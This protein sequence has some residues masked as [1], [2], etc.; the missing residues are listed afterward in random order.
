MNVP[1]HAIAKVKDEA[2]R[3]GY[4]RAIERSL[5]DTANRYVSL[6]RLEIIH[7]T[8]DHLPPRRSEDHAHISSHLATEQELLD[9][10]AEGTWD[11]TAELLALFR[12]G[13]RCLL[14]FVRGRRAGYTWVHTAGRPR[15]LPG[16]RI[17]IPD[18]YAYNFAGFT[19]PEFRGCGLQGYRHHELLGRPEWGDKKGLIGFVQCINWSSRRGQAKSGYRPLGAISLIGTRNRFTALFS[20]ELTQLGIR[21][22]DD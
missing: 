7:L 9:M 13:D 12:A 16:L 18:D 8:R 20:R 17:S 6:R 14:S 21:R 3:V 19:L 15:L 11:I 4:G 22:L 2:A 5:Y 10:Q 1:W